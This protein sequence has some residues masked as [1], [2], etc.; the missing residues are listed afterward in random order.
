MSTAAEKISK[1]QKEIKKQLSDFLFN[2]ER[3]TFRRFI[4]SIRE[5]GSW[6]S[7]IVVGKAEERKGPWTVVIN[8]TVPE[9]GG[10]NIDGTQ[11]NPIPIEEKFFALN[12]EYENYQDIIDKVEELA[13][14]LRVEDGKIYKCGGGSFSTC[15]EYGRVILGAPLPEYDCCE[16]CG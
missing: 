3:R 11:R 10:Y 7:P 16:E 5:F 13:L 15:Y 8:Q 9:D 12:G 6:Q 2:L 14:G 4:V 1:E